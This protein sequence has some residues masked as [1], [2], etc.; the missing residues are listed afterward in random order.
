MADRELFIRRL[1]RRQDA[2]E[3]TV[4]AKERVIERAGYVEGEH[5]PKQ[6]DQRPMHIAHV[7]VSQGYRAESSQRDE[8][9]QA[10]Q[11]QMAR[12]GGV[13]KAA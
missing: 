10:V 9:E 2:L 13:G 5:D 6:G 3:N 11:R 1:A 4:A 8:E 7:F 12:V